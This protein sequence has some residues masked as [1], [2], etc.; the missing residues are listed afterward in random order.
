MGKFK[1]AF[2]TLFKRENNM[3]VADLRDIEF[4]EVIDGHGLI[5]SMAD[6]VRLLMAL[7]DDGFI[8]SVECYT[9]D[10]ETTTPKAGTKFSRAGITY[11]VVEHSVNSFEMKYTDN[12]GDHAKCGMDYESIEAKLIIIT[13]L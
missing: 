1:A 11:T 12:K 4:P 13:G 10:G 3:T 2:N 5:G 7:S 8:D 6:L 9:V